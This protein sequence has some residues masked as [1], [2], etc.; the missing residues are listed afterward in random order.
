MATTIREIQKDSIHRELE[1]CMFCHEDLADPGLA[2]LDHV[3]DN[4]VCRAQYEDW[5]VNLDLD[6]PGG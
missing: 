6:R 4:S 5:L 1:E 3:E 2:F